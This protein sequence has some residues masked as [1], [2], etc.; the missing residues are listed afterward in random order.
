M[1]G[2]VLV[3]LLVL[4]LLGVVGSYTAGGSIHVLPAVVI[5][6]HQD[7][8][9]RMRSLPSVSLGPHRQQED[10]RLACVAR[11]VPR[12]SRWVQAAEPEAPD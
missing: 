6:G 5:L 8:W 12:H 2:A 3:F 9:Q 10:Q 7:A 1:L 4:W 11:Q